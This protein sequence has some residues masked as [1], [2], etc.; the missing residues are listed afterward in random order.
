[1]KCFLKGVAGAA[2]TLILATILLSQYSDYLAAAQTD[3]WLK[4]VEPLKQQIAANVERYQTLE[5]TSIN[6][7]AT[8]FSIAPEY[9]KIMPN[10]TIY[11][12][13]GKEGQLIVLVPILSGGSVTWRCIGGSRKHTLTCK[14][15]P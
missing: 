2:I 15:P 4:E 10:G 9:F 12:K 8:H 13:G 5:N 11:I 14:E 7:K 6:I 1:M 3:S